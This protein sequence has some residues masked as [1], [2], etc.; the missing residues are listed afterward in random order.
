M[1][2]LVFFCLVMYCFITCYLYVCICIHP[3]VILMCVNV[4]Y[5]AYINYLPE[6]IQALLA[7]MTTCIV[8]DYLSY[9]NVFSVCVTFISVVFSVE[10]NCSSRIKCNFI[11]ILGA[12][13]VVVLAYFMYTS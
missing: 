13:C 3:H 6:N 7:A 10:K 9:D 12:M 2:R 11:L 8:Y 1:P 4:W 5:I